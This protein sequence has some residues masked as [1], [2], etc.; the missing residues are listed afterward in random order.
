[1]AAAVLLAVATPA[2]AGDDIGAPPEGAVFVNAKDNFFQPDTVTV[3]LGTS[4]RWTNNGTTLHTVV[5][6][7][8][9]WQSNLLSPSSWF[10]VRFDSLGTF[11]YHCSRHDG[12][13][14]TV[15]VQ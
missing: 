7:T 6:E 2:C 10:E 5:S 13:T 4:V 11:D 8:G 12:M 15:I 9:L 1:M 14:G 3:A